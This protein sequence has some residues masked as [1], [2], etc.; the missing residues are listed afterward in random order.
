MAG[1]M[2]MALAFAF[3]LA[4]NAWAADEPLTAHDQ[5]AQMT[6]GVNI[7]GYDPLWK[8]PGKARFK[9][10]HMEIIRK[11][12]FDSVR[13]VLQAFAH[14]DEQDRLPRHWF[15]TLDGL[16]QAALAQGLTV[17]LDEH[18]FIFCGQEPAVCR[19]RLLSFWEQVAP[20]FASASNQV[21]FEILNEPHGKLD[22]EWNDLLAQALKVIRRT[23]P[24]RNVI[25]G[26]PF[27]NNIHALELLRLP[28]DDRHLI[29]TV[30]YY[31]PMRF[32]HQ[33][34]SWT[35]QYTELGVTWGTPRERE[36][37]END[38]DGVE[39]WSR[40]HDRP[41]YLGE[42]GAYDKAPME[43]RA[44]YTAAVARAAELRGWAWAYWQFD[45]DFIV[46]DIDNDHWVEPIHRALIPPPD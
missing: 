33:G 24:H 8:D 6:R 35:P 20:R 39:A 40:K 4:T 32:T 12:E 23:N 16:V 45:S 30:H 22:A 38:F 1:S 28:E 43:S 29:V 41:I 2:L 14:M 27:W 42:F 11:G 7:V 31:L 25:V 3:A 13:I 36:A 17:V 15:D 37:L 10:K 21:V 5:I 44:A 26:P 9:P 19:R 46:Y 18:D 34:A